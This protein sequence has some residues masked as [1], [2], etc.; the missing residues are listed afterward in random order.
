M[1]DKTLEQKESAYHPKAKMT[2]DSSGAGLFSASLTGQMKYVERLQQPI[3]QARAR[4]YFNSGDVFERSY[5][6]TSSIIGLAHGDG[7]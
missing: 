1:S 6:M 7:L 2:A 4:N 5:P 3:Y